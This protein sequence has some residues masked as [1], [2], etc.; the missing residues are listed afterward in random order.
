MLPGVMGSSSS[1][2][3]ASHWGDSGAAEAS[4]PYSVGKE[5]KLS[6]WRL[7]VHRSYPTSP[8]SLGLC[9]ERW[10]Q[11]RRCVWLPAS[12]RARPQPSAWK[13]EP[14]TSWHVAGIHQQFPKG[15]SAKPPVGTETWVLLR[16]PQGGPRPSFSSPLLVLLK[17]WLLKEFVEKLQK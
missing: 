8:L 11:R 15:I 3:T 17:C 2:I 13:E 12:H 14:V 4:A 16:K 1:I 6:R 9:V 5:D 7:L 10:L